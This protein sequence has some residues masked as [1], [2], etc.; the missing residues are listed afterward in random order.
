MGD[1]KNLQLAL[2]NAADFCTVEYAAQK[3]AVSPRTVRRYIASGRLTVCT[4][5]VADGES[6]AKHFMLAVA[7]V[8]E[9]RKARDRMRAVDA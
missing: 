6:E 5:R 9:L 7:D 8:T 3:L 2:P 1:M 4:P